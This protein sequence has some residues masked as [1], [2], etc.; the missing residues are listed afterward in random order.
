MSLRIAIATDAPGWHGERLQAAFA[1]RGAQAVCVSLRDCVLDLTRAA[2]G[3]VMPGFEQRLPDGVFVRQVP[4][5]TL[6][7]V[8][9][10]LDFLHALKELGVPVYNDGRAIERTVDKAMTSFLL[11]RAGIPTPPTWVAESADQ[12]R[13]IV[14]SEAAAGHEVV[15]KPLF[16]SQGK[17]LRRLGSAQALPPATEYAGVHYL[18]R[19]LPP[20]TE[21][22]RDWRVF[23][24]AGQAIAA[25]Q[26]L[27]QDWVNNVALGA[28]CE[29]AA[30]DAE[31]REL[32]EAACRAVAVDYGGVDIMRGRDGL[33][34]VVEVNGIPAWR[35]LQSVC[36]FD[37]AQRLVDDLL[38]RKLPA[39]ALSNVA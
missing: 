29:A 5:G 16:G 12:A 8:V 25:M 36:G 3:L 32:A 38:T 30:L 9:L 6:E 15:I 10:R 11:R 24:I 28:R 7:Q 19:F 4:G 21:G 23:V 31:L 20:G 37:I 13:A 33:A 34:Q 39:P 27:G 1:E 2:H 18:Q 22:Y 17:G 35:G 26:R 14:Q